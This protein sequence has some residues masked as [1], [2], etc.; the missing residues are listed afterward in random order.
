MVG[1][2][3]DVGPSVGLFDGLFHV[4]TTGLNRKRVAIVRVY[5]V[6]RGMDSLPYDLNRR[7]VGQLV[8]RSHGRYISEHYYSV[9]RETGRYDPSI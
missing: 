9:K 7:S 5:R 2:S 6:Y 3:V 4:T 1:R 8:G